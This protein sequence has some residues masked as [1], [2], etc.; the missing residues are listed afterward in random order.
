MSS[1]ATPAALPRGLNGYIVL[2]KTNPD[3]RNVWLAQAVSQ[4]GD[5]FN[6][7][8]L[9]GLVNQITGN[10]MAP[11]L[12]QTLTVLPN[13]LASLTF[14]GYLADRFD[15]RKIAVGIDV[16]R[17]LVAL[18]L[19]LV[20]DAATLWIAW[21]VIIFL[22][23]GEAIFGPAI[24]AAQPNLCKPHE[25]AAA[26]ALQQ[27]TW[28]SVSMLG[29]FVGGVVT[30]VF[31]RETAFV[32]NA[33]SFAVSALFILRV[34]GQFNVPGRSAGRVS[35]SALTEGARFMLRTP[36]VLGMSLVKTIFAIVF[37][38]AGLYS[39]FSYRIY[40]AGDAGTS[41]LYA[42][43]GIGSFLGPMLLPL[44][45]Q[46]K[47]LRDFF[48]IMVGGFLVSLTGYAVWGASGSIALGVL[49]IFV[50]HLGSGNMWANSRIYVQRETPDALRGRVM[51]L[52]MV[53]FTLTMGVLGLVWGVVAQRTSPGQG[54]LSA[55]GITAVLAVIW[56]L[57]MARRVRRAPS[58][59]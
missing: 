44:F 22:S 51:A 43:R 55:V 38:T 47:T 57:V 34:R 42:A 49:G 8:A 1:A 52:D 25:L 53:G 27:S 19:L 15:R 5:W 7:V 21:G 29:A 36:N 35:L 9:L 54:V 31:G 41:W 4:F 46:P 56:V 3:I 32:I 26:N 23:L 28:A 58:A 13:A 37:A 48:A 14:G 16:A 59:A 18:A 24:S 45:F 17:A 10:A 39:V 2:L 6:S 40:D 20:H 30:T 33:L 11:A 50:G 12:V